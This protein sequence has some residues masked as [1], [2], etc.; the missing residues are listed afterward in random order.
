MIGEREKETM[1]EIQYGEI[2]SNIEERS[3]IEVG[4]KTRKGSDRRRQ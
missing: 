1:N 4:I 3:K 2:K